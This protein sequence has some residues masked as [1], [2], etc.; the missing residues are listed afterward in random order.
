MCVQ[1]LHF[2]Q[3]E[4]LEVF[5]PRPLPLRRCLL[6]ST[7]LTCYNLLNAR[8]NQVFTAASSVASLPA[9]LQPRRVPGG[10]S[11]CRNVHR[12]TCHCA[13]AALS[14]SGLLVARSEPCRNSLLHT[15]LPEVD[16]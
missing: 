2:H 10:Q 16:T 11:S 5:L 13:R 14:S 7:A 12:T 1:N 3:D 8:H 6:A 9:G 4:R 15:E